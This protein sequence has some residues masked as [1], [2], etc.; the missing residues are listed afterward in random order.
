MRYAIKISPVWKPLF[1][2]FGFSQKSSYIEL[3]NGSLHFNFGTASETVPIE[4]VADVVHASWPFFYGLGA[5]LGPKGGV[6]YVGS[7]DGVVRVELTEPRPMNVWG[8]FATKKA[9]C[10]TVSVEEPDAF[11]EAVRAARDQATR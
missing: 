9:K 7:M 6:S 11:I 1:T 8:P 5:K 2:V 4:Q 10:V 3:D